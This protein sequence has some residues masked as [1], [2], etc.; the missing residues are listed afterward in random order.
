MYRI[1]RRTFK[2]MI[3]IEF[4]EHRNITHRYS[5]VPH[6]NNQLGHQTNQ[7][8]KTAT[9]RPISWTAWGSSMQ[10]ATLPII[11][12]DS[13]KLNSS[14]YINLFDYEKIYD[15]VDQGSLWNV[16]RHY[17]VLKR[18][19]N[20][21]QNSHDGFQWRVAHG[22]ELTDAFK[23]K[24][25]VREDWLLSPFLFLLVESTMN[26]LT[27]EAVYGIQWIARN[28]LEELVFADDLEILS[29]THQQMKVKASRIA[30]VSAEV[31]LSIQ[32]N[33][34]KIIKY[35]TE[36]SYQTKRWLRTSE[37]YRIFRVHGKHHQRKWRIWFGRKAEDWQWNISFA[38]VEKHM[39]LEVTVK[40]D[41]RQN[42]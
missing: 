35:N 36:N 18:L 12:E 29:H 2:Q 19:V 1:L 31:G 28:K 8:W 40:Q 14:L 32:I 22:V 33:K 5:Y 17:D 25:G 3:F 6:S 16:P 9:W 15:N 41:K 39:E 23:V 24:T 37:I 30:A 4:T 38:T 13:V 42:S 26:T 34:I 27:S 21:I 10:N 20:I 11:V 7:E